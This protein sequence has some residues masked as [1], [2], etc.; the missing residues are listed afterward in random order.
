MVASSS[1]LSPHHTA[2]TRRASNRQA[3]LPRCA[4]CGTP[5]HSRARQ[6][7]SI[8]HCPTCGH[9]VC[10]LEGVALHE[11]PRCRACEVLAGPHHAT[12]SLIDGLCPACARWAAKGLPDP[13]DDAE[14]DEAL[15]I[16]RR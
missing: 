11:H 3:R 6:V 13:V 10:W 4:R 9:D 5:T 12:T 14:D 16:G 1:A 7:E 8:A 2:G 15:A